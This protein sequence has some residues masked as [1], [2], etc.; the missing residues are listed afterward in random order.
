VYDGTY[1]SKAQSATVGNKVD[2]TDL[3]LSASDVV[4]VNWDPTLTP[5]A[6]PSRTPKNAVQVSATRTVPT[7]FARIIGFNTCTVSTVAVMLSAQRSPRGIIGLSAIDAGNNTYVGSY[8]SSANRNVNQSSAADNGAL[9]SNGPI[10]GSNNSVL[11]GAAV[12]G[13]TGTI[14]GFVVHGATVSGATA[15]PTPAQKP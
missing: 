10:T 14:V 1:I 6:D 2:G 7:M 9:I 4:L 5:H 11:N 3:A 12:L 15:T 8:R 13:P